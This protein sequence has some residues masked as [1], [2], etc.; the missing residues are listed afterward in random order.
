MGSSVWELYCLEHGLNS[1]GTLPPDL[2]VEQ[3]EGFTS[4]FSEAATGKYIPL[5]VM[6]DLEPTVIGKTRFMLGI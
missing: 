4:F 1:D 6:V 2:G 5:A 3:Y